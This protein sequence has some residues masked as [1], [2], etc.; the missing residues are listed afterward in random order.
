MR[1]I[2]TFFAKKVL[3]VWACCKPLLQSCKV[4]FGQCDYA[5]T[6]FTTARSVS[7]WKMSH[8]SRPMVLLL[9][10]HMQMSFWYF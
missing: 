5:I 9:L 4:E 7:N 2:Y 10:C 8:H 3:S 6:N 1:N